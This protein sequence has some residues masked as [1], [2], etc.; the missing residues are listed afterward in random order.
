MLAVAVLGAR[1]R[2]G[3]ANAVGELVAVRAVAGLVAALGACALGCGAG[4]LFACA[5]ACGAALLG[6][7]A[8]LQP[9]RSWDGLKTANNFIYYITECRESSKHLRQHSQEKGQLHRGE[10]VT[11]MLGQF[12]APKT[13]SHTSSIATVSERRLGTRADL[14]QGGGNFSILPASAVTPPSAAALSRNKI[15]RARAR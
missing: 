3:R 4:L 12:G 1:R 15:G 14:Q 9:K 6:V 10:R 8:T 5:L 2:W 11:R 7:C 13:A